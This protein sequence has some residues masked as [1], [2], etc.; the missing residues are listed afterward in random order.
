MTHA[1][2]ALAASFH[3]DGRRRIGAF[4]LAL[5]A[6][7]I[8]DAQR[9]LP[10]LVQSALG[11][12]GQ[13]TMLAKRQRRGIAVFAPQSHR[14]DGDAWL[15]QKRGELWGYIPANSAADHFKEVRCGR[16]AI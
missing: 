5:T 6:I 15:I 11:A 4:A 13:K 14:D 10:D 3:S 2:H 9:D 1:G 12:L 16:V 8:S 7:V